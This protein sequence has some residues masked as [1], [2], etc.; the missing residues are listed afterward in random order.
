MSAVDLFALFTRL[1]S[2]VKKEQDI[3]ELEAVYAEQTKQWEA[4]N[5]AN[6]KMALKIVEIRIS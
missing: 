3:Q 2:E 6:L 5:Q 4:E 1:S